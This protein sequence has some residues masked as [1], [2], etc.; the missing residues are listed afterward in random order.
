MMKQHDNPREY[1]RRYYR[2]ASG[3]I[4]ALAVMYGAYF[5]T[6]NGWFGN[7]LPHILLTF[8]AVQFVVQ[9]VVFLHVGQESKPRFTLWSVVYGFIMML[10]IVVASLWIMANMNYNMHLSPDRMNEYMLQQNKKG[11]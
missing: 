7:Y 1:K 6:L 5:A 9:L 3:F 11:Y 10:I 8:A 4:A 2:Y